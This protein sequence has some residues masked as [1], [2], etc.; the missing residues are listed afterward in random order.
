MIY[1]LKTTQPVANNHPSPLDSPESIAINHTL[2]TSSQKPNPARLA[3][4]TDTSNEHAEMLQDETY[5]LTQILTFYREIPNELT[6][7]IERRNL[8]NH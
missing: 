3:D 5:D 4:I 8:L 2:C 1:Y 6:L 7:L